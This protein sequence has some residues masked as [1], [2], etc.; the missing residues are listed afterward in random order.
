MILLKEITTFIFPVPPTFLVNSKEFPDCEAIFED[1]SKN[2]QNSRALGRLFIRLC[3]LTGLSWFV[4][5][6]SMLVFV[7]LVLTLLYHWGKGLDM[8]T[9]LYVGIFSC[10]S[11]IA[12]LCTILFL[13]RLFFYGLVMVSLPLSKRCYESVNSTPSMTNVL[14]N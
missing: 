5:A 11:I 3:R 12:I 4:W 10:N 7:C 13:S 1:I 14:S 6:V 8:S 2:S 9:V